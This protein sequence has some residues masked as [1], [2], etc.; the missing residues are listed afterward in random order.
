M[1][2]Q[3]APGRGFRR[4]GDGFV[5]RDAVGDNGTRAVVM[6]PGLAEHHQ[7]QQ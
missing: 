4:P 6:A 7:Q 3:A 5:V 1:T 2:P